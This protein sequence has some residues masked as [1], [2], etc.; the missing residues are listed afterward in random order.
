MSV[1]HRIEQ[2]DPP[3]PS[4]HWQRPFTQL[5]LLK[6]IVPSMDIQEATT[7]VAFDAS[8]HR[9]TTSRTCKTD[10]ILQDLCIGLL[11]DIVIA[12]IVI[13]FS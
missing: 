8:S 11:V 3:Y 7:Q 4:W 6:Q 13:A 2:S 10:V 9:E 5:P 1:G 12:A